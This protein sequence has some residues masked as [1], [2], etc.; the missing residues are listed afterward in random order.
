MVKKSMLTPV[1]AGVLAVTVVGSGAG[2]YFKFV[3]DDGGSAKAAKDE[4][5]GGKSASLT[6]DQAASNIE[7]QLDKAQQIAKG[8]LEGGYSMELSYAP[9]SAE[10]DIKPISMTVDAKQK[11]K[12]SAVDYNMKYDSQSLI[13]LN[14]V[15]DNESETVYVKVPELSDAYL[16]ATAEDIQSAMKDSLSGSSF[17]VTED[18]PD[19]SSI[20][21]LENVDFDALFTDIESYGDTIKDNAPAATDGANR[22]VE[23]GGK[24]VE[25]TTKAY[26][27]T[28]DDF[29]KVINAVSDKWKADETMKS[30]IV[31]S[32]GSDEEE[33]NNMWQ[34][35][36]E[37]TNGTG[38][39]V[40]IE[41]YYN[42]D[43]VQGFSVK[44]P[45][46]GGTPEE[47]YAICAST[48]DAYIVDWSFME[49]DGTGMTA[50]GALTLDG[51]TLDGSISFVSYTEDYRAYDYES[52]DAELPIMQ[53]TV[54]FTCDQ[55]TATDDSLTGTM[56]ITA[57]DGE[58]VYTF[59]NSG[60][61]F[62][63]SFSM[64][65]DGEDFGTVSMKGQT[66]DASDITVPTGT[67][68]NMADE[69]G[70]DSY[71]E[72]CDV[73]GW[74]ASV[75]SIVGDELYDEIFGS[76]DNYDMSDYDD[77]DYSQDYGGGVGDYDFDDYDF[78]ESLYTDDND[79]A[80]GDF[81]IG[82]VV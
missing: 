12:L 62:D 47:V 81:G 3:K 78:D 44:N 64:K 70:M 11:D 25:L 40:N 57:D 9:G 61:S 28:Y 31:D 22:R 7:A 67:M 50:A 74:Q 4:K 46:E 71:L 6:I 35:M 18:T 76:Q 43:E 63:M 75:K 29:V 1:L 80:S 20:D 37:N 27:V 77:Y 58:M 41:I 60:E 54:T 32:L 21:A 68:Y 45:E 82:K 42:G 72:G 13:T 33:Y 48:D 39:T 24:S 55:V 30:F 79:Y 49:D 15:Y 51:D 14:A 38:E 36:L 56:K 5:D 53:E 26:A 34:S 19:T 17:E 23:Q 59:N 69:A 52:P 8:E 66:T 65:A 2:Y 73:E 16:T 10:P